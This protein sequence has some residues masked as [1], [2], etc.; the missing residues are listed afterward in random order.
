MIVSDS[1]IK[2]NTKNQFFYIFTPKFSTYKVSSVPY[3][4][5]RAIL[6]Y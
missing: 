6:S 5:C 2:E 4:G 1:A 3:L